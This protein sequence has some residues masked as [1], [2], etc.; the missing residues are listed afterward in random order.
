MEDSRELQLSEPSVAPANRISDYVDPN[1]SDV[2][3]QFVDE[4]CLERS[5]EIYAE[6]IS[7]FEAIERKVGYFRMRNDRY[8]K[9][10]HAITKQRLAREAQC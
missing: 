4:K 10:F 2:Q 7:E 9:G 1:Q 3:T 8:G 5:N 6:E